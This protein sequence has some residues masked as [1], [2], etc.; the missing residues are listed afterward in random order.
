MGG[1]LIMDMLDGN[2]T[3]TGCRARISERALFD[4]T[5]AAGLTLMI[6]FREPNVTPRS[7]TIF[8]RLKEGSQ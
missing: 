8:R 4:K 7:V 6:L 2:A 3:T 1:Y 5:N